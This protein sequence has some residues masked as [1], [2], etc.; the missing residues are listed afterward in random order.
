MSTRYN[1]RRRPPGT[2]VS[3]AAQPT[4]PG[5]RPPEPTTTTAPI[6]GHPLTGLLG[7]ESIPGSLGSGTERGESASS[8]LSPA[9]V[10]GM[11]T[12]QADAHGALNSPVSDAGE[13]VRR[14]P[15]TVEDGTDD[16]DGPWIPVQRRRRARSA[17]AAPPG[18]A[19]IPAQDGPHLTSPQLQ[20]HNFQYT[21]LLDY[22]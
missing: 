2:E 22:T 13:G 8:S 3:S 21:T 18:R 17:D 9:V 10:A 11:V 16:D 12:A 19:S 20:Q 14:F 4:A 1:L 5:E 15:V 6:P 7:V